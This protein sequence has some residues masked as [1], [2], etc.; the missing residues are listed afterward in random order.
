MFCS[1]FE[2]VC[3]IIEATVTASLTEQNV[4]LGIKVYR[5]NRAFCS[6]IE[7]VCLVIEAT[8]RSVNE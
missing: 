1:V 3:L 4:Q 6:D 7:A 8:K 5:N 2:A